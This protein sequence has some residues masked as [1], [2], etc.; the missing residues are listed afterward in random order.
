VRLAHAYWRRS[1]D[2]ARFDLEW[3]DTARRIIATFREQQR[4]H[5]EGPYRFQRD[6]QS[7]LDTLVRDG[8]GKRGAETRMVRSGFRPSDDAVPGA[9]DSGAGD[10]AEGAARSVASAGG[11]HPPMTRN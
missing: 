10:C 8:L 4:L 3:R 9:A 1:G 5:D 6:G 2:T 11:M 7:R